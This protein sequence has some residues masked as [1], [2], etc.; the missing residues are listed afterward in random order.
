MLKFVYNKG[1]MKMKIGEYNVEVRRSKRKSATI[2]ITAD[3]QI[4][5]FVP[6]Y[7]SDNEIEKMV[8][9]KS[10]WIDKHMLKVQST[11]DERSKLE[12]ITFEQVK[13]LADQAVE[14]IPKRVKYYAEKENFVY[15]KITIKN[16]VSRWGSCSTKGNLNF[17]CLLMLT[18]DYVIDYIV[19]HELCHLREMNHSEKFWAEVEKIMPDY[20]RA[21]LWLK[22]NGGNL[23]SRMRG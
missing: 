3:M 1:M 23:I 2:K 7:V 15:N 17:N 14:Y 16:L 21:E 5:V 11:I 19:V 10:K 9:S 20:Q 13:E 18:P 12:K 8:I 4:V 6:L 22:Q